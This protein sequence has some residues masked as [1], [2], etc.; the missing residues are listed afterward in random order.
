MKEIKVR[1]KN[2]YGQDLYYPACPESQFFC[3]IANTV[4]LKPSTI[5]ILKKHKVKITPVL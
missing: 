4:T 5:E 3:D 2:V 1:I